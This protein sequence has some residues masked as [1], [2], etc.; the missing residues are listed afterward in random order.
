MKYRIA[1]DARP[2]FRL[3]VLAT[4]ASIALWLIP[5]ASIL[6]YPFR[7]FVTFIHEGSH[8]LAAL[9]TGNTVASLSVAPDGSG[10]TYATQGFF[11]GVLI[12]SAGYLGAMTFGVLL[13]FAIRKSVKSKLVLFTSA[14]I[15][16]ALTILFGLF[17]PILTFSGLS[18]IPFTLISG[19]AIGAGLIAL[20]MYA[21]SKVAQF[22]V[23]FLAVQCV[24]NALFDLGNV[25]LL[26]TPLNG[27]RVMTDAVNMETATHIPAFFWTLIWIGLSVVLLTIGLR[28]YAA[29]QSAT[30]PTQPDLPFESATDI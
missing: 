13:L 3:L 6:T 21:S 23:G 17:K 30:R 15:V 26:S 11:S 14:G 19:V 4:I 29:T 27:T 24:L 9:L 12:S 7:L 25:F 22:F 1:A 20:G 2:Q 5:Y 8:A 28:L 10:L 16:L 18:G